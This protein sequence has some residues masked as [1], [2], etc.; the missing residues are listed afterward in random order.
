M[1]RIG[2]VE[3]PDAWKIN[4]VNESVQIRVIDIK[5]ASTYNATE[6]D[7]ANL[8]IIRYSGFCKTPNAQSLNVLDAIATQF[9]NPK[10]TD[11]YINVDEG[12]YA[13]LQNFSY[14]KT[15]GRKNYWTFDLGVIRIGGPD[16]KKI[17]YNTSGIS[18]VDNEFDI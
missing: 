17:T 8:P 4:R 5:L 6:L 9:R 14:R 3:L 2:I 16:E 12:F 11:F 13:Y 10:I 7:G 18:I 15:G 1:R